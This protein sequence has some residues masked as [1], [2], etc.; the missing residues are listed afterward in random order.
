MS[1]FYCI[2][3]KITHFSRHAKH[4][5][6]FFIFMFRCSR[7]RSRFISPLPRARFAGLRCFSRKIRNKAAIFRSTAYRRSVCATN[8]CLLSAY[9]CEELLCHTC[10]RM[11]LP[12]QNTPFRLCFHKH[13]GLVLPERRKFRPI[14]FTVLFFSQP[15]AWKSVSRRRFAIHGQWLYS[16]L[17]R[18]EA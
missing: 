5:V 16:H 12:S 17:P 1:I 18:H 9:L 15:F 8:K 4:F 3:G 7:N 6:K 10:F 14:A 2:C 11:P 13:T